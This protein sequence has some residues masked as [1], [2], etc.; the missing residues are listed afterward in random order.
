MNDECGVSI[1][2]AHLVGSGS[3]INVFYHED[4][5]RLTETNWQGCL[6][7]AVG[8]AVIY[9]TLYPLIYPWLPSWLKIETILLTWEDLRIPGLV[10]ATCMI[11]G[12]ILI[13]KESK[14]KQ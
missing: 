3:P 7:I 2:V 8:L 11:I 14:D 10:A 6:R 1:F 4:V 5:I 9:L 12:V 13:H